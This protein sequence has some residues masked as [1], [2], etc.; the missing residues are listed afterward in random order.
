MKMPGMSAYAL[1]VYEGVV[2]G[3]AL[4]KIRRE[5]KEHQPEELLSHLFTVQVKLNEIIQVFSESK[6]DFSEVSREEVLFVAS[7]L[8]FLTIITRVLISSLK[9]ET[10]AKSTDEKYRN[11]VAT[12]V[13]DM[14]GGQ[15][16][17]EEIAEAWL[18][19]MDDTFVANIKQTVIQSRKEGREPNEILDW[20]DILAST[21]D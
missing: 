13:E 9:A 11:T 8:V 10:I 12:V 16:K 17:L 6:A 2:C 3:L 14:A 5:E 7:G 15:E 21:K 19:A 4:E 20:R 18:L 1:P